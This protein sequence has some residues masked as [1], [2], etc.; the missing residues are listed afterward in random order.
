[1]EQLARSRGLRIMSNSVAALMNDRDERLGILSKSSPT[2]SS[3]SFWACRTQFGS[4][5]SCKFPTSSPEAK[6]RP[7]TRLSPES[8]WYRPTLAQPALCPTSTTRLYPI[9][10]IPDPGGDIASILARNTPVA[11]ASHPFPGR[12]VLSTLPRACIRVFTGIVAY[13]RAASARPIPT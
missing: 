11:A 6:T 9:D 13:P 7:A 2:P 12:S 5:A 3:T 4:P 1:M 8:A 10:P